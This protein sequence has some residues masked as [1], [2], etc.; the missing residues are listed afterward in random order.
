MKPGNIMEVQKY[1]RSHQ[2][3]ATSRFKA[4][5]DILDGMDPKGRKAWCIDLEFSTRKKIVYEMAI[6][7]YHTGAVVLDTLAKQEKR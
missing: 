5:L 1:I 3:E 2:F 6:V 7:E 4:T